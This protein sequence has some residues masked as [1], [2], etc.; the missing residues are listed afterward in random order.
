MREQLY[1][2]TTRRAEELLDTLPPQP[3]RRQYAQ[4]SSALDLHLKQVYEEN[5]AVWKRYE[6]SV[7]T[8]K[9]RSRSQSVTDTV[10]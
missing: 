7:N 9:D 3:S 4:L 1:Q 2:I 6:K 5:S 8:L 10:D